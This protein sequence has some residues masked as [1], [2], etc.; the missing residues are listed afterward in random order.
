MPG[1]DGA[2]EVGVRIYRPANATGALP[3]MLFIHG[4]GMVL[5][6]L[7]TDHL[8]AVMLCE[9]VGAVI[10]SVDYRLAPEN[11]G[12]RRHRGLLR[13]P[14]VDGVPAPTSSASTPTGWRSTAAAP[15]A[16][17]PSPRPWWRAT[18]AA[19]PCAS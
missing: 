16:G 12:T 3:G 13:R 7:D 14:A 5:G 9:T 4:G 8:T 18:A 2:P 17:W 1:P 6:N 10:V 19:R 11:P 15:A